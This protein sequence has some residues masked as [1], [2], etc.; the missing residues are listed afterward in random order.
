MKTGEVNTNID[1]KLKG[2]VPIDDN[3]KMFDLGV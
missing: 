3:Y 1:F 2:D